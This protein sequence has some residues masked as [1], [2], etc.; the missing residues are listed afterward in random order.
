MLSVWLSA[1][2]LLSMAGL[3]TVAVAGQEGA[4]IKV[5]VVLP[6]TGAQQKFGEIENNSFLMGMEEINAAGGV[7]G[8][9]IELLIEDDK[10]QLETVWPQ[11]VAT[12]A[13]IYNE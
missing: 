5:G 9:P 2:V 3:G 12:K 13:Y 4:L 7:N 10:S 8:R 11:I 1:A 6:L